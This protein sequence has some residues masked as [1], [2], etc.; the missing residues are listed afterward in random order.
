[1]KYC[2]RDYQEAC[3]NSVIKQ[4]E[5]VRSTIAVLY[6][7]G[8]KTVIFSHLIER[9]RP[10]RFL[11]LAHRGELINQAHK[12]V[13]EVTGLDF[14]IEMASSTAD[15]NLFSNVP[16]V[17]ATVQTMNSGKGPKKRMH[18]FPPTYFD[19]I[20][21]DE[22]HR[23]ISD[24]YVAI[25]NYFKQNPNLKIVGFTAT[26]GRADGIG[27]NN[28]FDSVA[29]DEDIRQG[30]EKGWLCNVT[31][32]FIPV[33]GLDYS[34]IKTVDGDFNQTQ[35]AAIME[36]EENIAGVCHPALE[37]IYGLTPK[38]LEKIPVPEWGKYIV[39]QGKPPRRTIVFTVSVAQAEACCNIFNRVINGLAKW[40]C[41]KTDPEERK[42]TLAEFATGKTAVVVNVGVLTEGYDNPYA[43]VVIMARPTKS[44]GLYKQMVGRIIRTLPGVLDALHNATPEERKAAIKASAKPFCRV[45]DLDGSSGSHSLISCMD[46]LAGELSPEAKKRVMQKAKE[47][48]R[49]VRVMEELTHAEHA[50]RVE[51]AE[52]QRR[53]E[54]ARKAKL[55]AKASFKVYDV[56][57]FGSAHLS[58]AKKSYNHGV[59]ITENQLRFFSLYL[60]NFKNP[61]RLSKA[62]A[63]GIIGNKVAEWEARKNQNTP[64]PV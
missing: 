30:I 26:P 54:E 19:A 58:H 9:L 50:I 7:G 3:L 28:I 1:M 12:K 56:D 24:S 22:C 10:K 43:E 17:I 61:E 45:I 15:S 6:T 41:G 27:M 51:K 36:A 48:G 11:I 46:I 37:V 40:V 60:K 13:L 8:G 2:L 63:R 20:I 47:S 44:E 29:F 32:Q 55:I 39:A 25:L 35:L 16:G 42:K 33:H 5:T 34:H 64:P 38:T 49:P 14:G 59:P 57:P 62:Q 52:Q 21:I 53:E 31:Q 4:W 23:G 18:K